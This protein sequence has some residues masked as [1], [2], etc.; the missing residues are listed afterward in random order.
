M[1]KAPAKAIITLT[2]SDDGTSINVSARFSPPINHH[3][4]GKNP[5]THYTATRA[6]IF[7]EEWLQGGW[8]NDPEM[9]A[10]GDV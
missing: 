2:E 6:V 10:S 4:G 5:L 3:K 1:R 8:E 9:E 7:I